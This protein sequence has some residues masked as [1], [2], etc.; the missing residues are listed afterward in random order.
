MAPSA[1]RIKSKLLSLEFKPFPKLAFC[2]TLGGT[3]CTK[4]G[5][6]T[7][8]EFNILVSEARF[9]YRKYLENIC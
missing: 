2:Y 6:I 5:I 3:R 7:L 1:L 4:H 9:L 8:E